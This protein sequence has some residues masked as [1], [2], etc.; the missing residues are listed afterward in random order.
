MCF[1]RAID[2]TISGAALLVVLLVAAEG[3]G[4]RELAQ[5]VTDHGLG[6]EHGDVL[7]SVVDRDRVT[8]HGR[9]DHGPTGPGLDDVL[10]AGFV[11]HDHLAK[12]VIVDEGPFLRLRGIFSY[13][14]LR[15]LPA[16]RRRTMY[17]SLSLLA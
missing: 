6:H 14:Y 3:A 1:T 2:S 4:G 8:Q 10:G 15:F 5:L 9:D 11:L 7:A 12:Q 13:S 17:L 16:L